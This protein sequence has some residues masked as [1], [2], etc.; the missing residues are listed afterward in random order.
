MIAGNPVGCIEMSNFYACIIKPCSKSVEICTGTGSG[1]L[2]TYRP[3]AGVSVTDQINGI[4]QIQKSVH[5]LPGFPV[6]SM[7]SEFRMVRINQKRLYDIGYQHMTLGYDVGRK[8]DHLLID[9]Y[10]STLF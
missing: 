4:P 6:V 7:R 5:H 2:V 10:F 1:I 3:E 8:P 9:I